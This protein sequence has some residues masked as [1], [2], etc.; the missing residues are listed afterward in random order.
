[1]SGRTNEG[2]PASVLAGAGLCPH[3]WAPALGD[4]SP[5]EMHQRSP[6]LG[7]RHTLAPPRDLTQASAQGPHVHL[8]AVW[9]LW[10]SGVCLSHQ[11]G[12]PGGQGG[13]T[14][15]SSVSRT[16]PGTQGAPVGKS[17][18]PAAHP[19]TGSLQQHDLSG[20]KAR[21]CHPPVMGGAQDSCSGPRGMSADARK[22]GICAGGASGRPQEPRPAAHLTA[23]T[24]ATSPTQACHPQP[25]PAPSTPSRQWKL[26]PLSHPGASRC[27]GNCPAVGSREEPAT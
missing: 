4:V 24:L 5:L 15:G 3:P 8:G 12:N 7:T 6:T 27:K 16:R 10:E 13:S 18:E 11:S 1:M 2:T 22:A 25:S 26:L 20:H 23:E 14:S 9:G 21:A 17:R 19:Q